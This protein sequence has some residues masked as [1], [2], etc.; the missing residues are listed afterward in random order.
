MS[1]K[2]ARCVLEGSVK[3]T[4][5]FTQEG[6]GPTKVTGEVTGL[7]PGNHGFHVHQFGDVSTGEYIFR[8]TVSGPDIVYFRDTC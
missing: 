5:T 6:D 4:I 3:G 2:V 1:A 8:Y 7:S